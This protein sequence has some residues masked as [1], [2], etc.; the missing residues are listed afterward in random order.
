[1]GWVE[2]REDFAFFFLPLT[3]VFVLKDTEEYR[4]KAKEFNVWNM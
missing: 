4:S 2:G 1:M 3:S